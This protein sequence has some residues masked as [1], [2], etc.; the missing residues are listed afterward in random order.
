MLSLRGHVDPCV[1]SSTCFSPPHHVFD[2]GRA[3][4]VTADRGCCAIYTESECPQSQCIRW[5][6]IL[7]ADPGIARSICIDVRHARRGRPAARLS[8]LY[9]TAH[10]ATGVPRIR[11]CTA[12]DAVALCDSASAHGIACRRPALDR[13]TGVADEPGT[14]GLSARVPQQDPWR[15]SELG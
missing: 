1:W 3:R 7:D 8:L 12:T 9:P 10:L 11:S 6:R 5:R 14:G 2:V 15:R 13:S 4:H